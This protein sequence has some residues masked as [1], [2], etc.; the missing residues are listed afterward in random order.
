MFS[1]ATGDVPCNVKWSNAHRLDPTTGGKCIHFTAA[2]EGDIF[3]VFAGIPQKHETWLY[4]QIS[5][6]GV[7]L[8]K[9]MRVLT[10]QLQDGASSLGSSN[11]YQSY[12][13]CV[14][15]ETIGGV[16]I[17]QYGKT[18][19]N[20]ELPHIWLEFEIDEILSLQYY[21]F[22]SGMYPVKVMGV[23]IIDQ[24]AQYFIVCR[25]G[26]PRKDNGRCS[27]Q[28]HEE[29]DG[30]R[31]TGSDSPTD[32]IACK[33]Y[34]VGFPYIEGDSGSFTCVAT[35]PEHMDP[36]T[37]T[38]KCTCIRQ[39]EDS[40]DGG[41]VTCVTECPLTHYDDGNVCK[42]CST[43]CKDVSGR[44]TRVCTGPHSGDCSVCRYTTSDGG[45][46]E[47]CSP[48]QKAVAQDEG[49]F[50]CDQC[51]PGHKCMRG[52]AMEEICPAGTYSSPERTSCLECAAGQFSSS[53]SQYCQDC[54][55]GQYSANSGASTC[56]ACPSGQ[57]SSSSGSSSCQVC[58]AGQYS[59]SA[60]STSCQDCPAGQFS[61]RGGSSSCDDCPAG[62]YSAD[63]GSSGCQICQPGQYSASIGSTSCQ[64]C[65]AGQFSR[66]GAATRCND[67]P[68][69]QYSADVGSSG[70][71]VCQPGQYSVSTGST[72]CQ[73]CPA[74]QFSRVG[75]ATRCN[76][77]PAG[78]Y[79]AE[80]GSSGCEACAEGYTSE[81][82]ATE[83]YDW[84]QCS[85]NPCE[86][87]GVCTDGVDSFTCACQDPYTGDRCQLACPADWA[88]H[89]TECFHLGESSGDYLRARSR[90]AA[91]H[92]SLLAMPKD[93]ATNTFI[94]NLISSSQRP[95]GRYWIGLND[96]HRDSAEWQDTTDDRWTWED[97]TPLGWN[98]WKPGEPNG[99]HERC[100]MII[101]N[102]DDWNDLVCTATNLYYVCQKSAE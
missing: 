24:P 63:A 57:Y 42:V 26:T 85:P 88:S 65:P 22:G 54:P 101:P 69:G 60:G 86:N 31:T 17:I 14:T 38:S 61:A 35:C 64:E 6:E 30:C 74:G 98:N 15:E 55:A 56:A 43:L 62:Q 50:R 79:S 100:A 7:A 51:Q 21:A 87:N 84:D 9:S 3:V 41:T 49:G 90:C 77:C 47:G 91:T 37:E 66:V 92:N 89:G 2:S 82:G 95:G 19:D 40:G 27:Q 70:C 76:D 102:R 25:E 67:C 36:A 83:C 94:A 10:T 53:G 58:P 23:S 11:L 44:G 75:A 68:A 48:G 78:Q 71:Q 96:L 8:Y 20:E 72:S 4:V 59:A 80:A 93:E 1:S 13:V 34:S 18:P 39:M 16:T 97:N 52:D 32:C 12:F 5:P 28:C 81:E 46:L 29:C 73:D 45:C 99:E 33:H